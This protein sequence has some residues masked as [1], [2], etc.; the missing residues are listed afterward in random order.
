MFR[1]KSKSTKN[2]FGEV[3]TNFW[4]SIIGMKTWLLPKLIADIMWVFIKLLKFWFTEEFRQTAFQLNRNFHINGRG[5]GFWQSFGKKGELE[6]EK[7]FYF[8][9]S[10][11]CW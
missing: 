1:N 3:I 2:Q 11:K 5:C 4:N 9:H 7:T 6:I 10:A 8:S